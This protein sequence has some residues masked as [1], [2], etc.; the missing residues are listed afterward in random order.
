MLLFRTPVLFCRLT[1]LL[2]FLSFLSLALPQPAGAVARPTGPV[3]RSASGHPYRI[4]T[5]LVRVGLMRFAAVETLVL[6]ADPGACLIG[7]D[8]QERAAGMGPW[9]FTATE[10]G[11]RAVDANSKDLGM[12]AAGTCWRLQSADEK[13][14]LGIG[15]PGSRRPRFYRGCL[16]IGLAGR[17]LRAINE[18]MLESYLRGVVA[19]EMGSRAPL[20]ALKAQ[21]V[22]SRTY[23]LHCL[24]Q[25]KTSGYDVRDTTDSQVYNGVDGETP[26]TDQAVRETAGLVLTRDDR[27]IAALFCADCGGFTAPGAGPDDCPRAV[28]DSEAHAAE[29]PWVRRYTPERLA[30]LLARSAA[31]RGLGALE[32]VTVLDKDVSGRARRLQL[33]FRAAPGDS[34]ESLPPSESSGDTGADADDETQSPHKGPAGT[35]TPPAPLKGE[36]RPAKAAKRAPPLVREISANSLRTLL[37]V[38]TLRSTL[39]TVRRDAEGAFVF[40][41]RGWGHGRGMCQVGAMALASPPYNQDFK[42]IL[43]H[44]YAGAT[45]AQANAAETGGAPATDN[46]P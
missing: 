14:R 44:Y 25:W 41:G 4:E 29:R 19:C 34:P 18:V 28:D 22:A 46:E 27:P 26:A 16:E 15:L 10:Q 8:G 23:A 36:E 31:L 13:T 11:V 32:G 2:L 12:A 43:L 6:S 24:G 1:R 21:A 5:P 30:A 45:L 42:T 33:T 38:D 7:P 17:R 3:T 9:T 39:F 35:D 40:E 20:E 37:G